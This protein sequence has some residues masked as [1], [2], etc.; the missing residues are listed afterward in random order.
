M[1]RWATG[2]ELINYF[3]YITKFN[4]ADNLH[5]H[6]LDDTYSRRGGGGDEECVRL[7]RGPG[8][9]NEAEL[10]ALYSCAFTDGLSKPSA[11]AMMSVIPC[12]I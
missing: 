2:V 10:R 1:E 8:N 11:V 6:V 4:K 5:G 9:D 7:C 12:L 3:K